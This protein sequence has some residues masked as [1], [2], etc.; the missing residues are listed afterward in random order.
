MPFFA[1]CSF[2]GR[3]RKFH[4]FHDFFSTN[5]GA[6]FF[7]CF[8]TFSAH[9]IVNDFKKEVKIQAFRKILPP[10]SFKK[11]WSFYRIFLSMVWT[12]IKL[13]RS[14]IYYVCIRNIWNIRHNRTKKMAICI[15]FKFQII[16]LS[17]HIST[18]YTTRCL[19]FFFAIKLSIKYQQ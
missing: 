17:S 1:Q 16:F 19:C 9:S 15:R 7:D 13:G 8:F 4:V 14:F 11:S 3:K 12:K 6:F 18:V 10:M 5:F 2:M